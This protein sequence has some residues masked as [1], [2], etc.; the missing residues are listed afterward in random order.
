MI[1]KHYL[2][3]CI[4]SFIGFSTILIQ[5]I[6]YYKKGQ[7]KVNFIFL[8]ASCILFCVIDF[9][10]GLCALDII[11]SDR[12]FFDITTLYY[13]VS[14]GIAFL[15]AFF[16]FYFCKDSF[17][18]LIF[19]AVI[20]F[21]PLLM[22][23]V[24]LVQNYFTNNL[25]YISADGVYTRNKQIFI[26]LV[27][28]MHYIYY[29]VCFF[30]SIYS[31]YL[32]TKRSEH[33]SR[34]VILFPILPIISSLL[35]YRDLAQ[36]H[37]SIGYFIACLLIYSFENSYSHGQELQASV[38]T[39]FKSI[40]DE[41]TS[42]LAYESVP[43]ENISLLLEKL[44]KYYNADDAFISVFT[45]DKINLEHI[46]YWNASR[47]ARFL[48]E[49]INNLPRDVYSEWYHIIQKRGEIY[50]SDIAFPDVPKSLSS[51]CKKL[52][53][54]NFMTVPIVNNGSIVAIMTV[55]NFDNF[56]R[57]FTMLRTIA[58][59][60]F[61]E[62]LKRKA[63]DKTEEERK[64]IISALSQG[65]DCIYYIN[66]NEDQI[67]VYRHDEKVERFFDI[68]DN[69]TVPFK[70]SY[71]F[72]VENVV[73]PEEQ[74]ELLEFGSVEVLKSVLRGRK[75][76]TK[77]FKSHITEVPETFEAKW[78]KVEPEDQEAQHV[79]LG[80]TNIEA[81]IQQRLQEEKERQI[82]QN[83]L[84]L[85]IEVAE[86]VA[87][88]SQFDKLTGVYNKISGLDIMSKFLSA[89]DEDESYA[90]LFFDLDKF[91]DINDN[92]GHLEGDEIL[93]GVGKA[94]KH[95]CRNCD[96]AV[97]FGGD[98]FI[99]LVKQMST[100]TEVENFG[101]QIVEQIEKLARGKYYYTTCSMGGY[102]TK[103]RDLQ[104]SL[105]MAD[106]SLYDVKNSGRDGIKI[107]IDNTL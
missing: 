83:K 61:S 54:K 84:D 82:V 59:F 58:Y 19:I 91:K 92:H 100:A 80:Y 37:L 88:E 27:Y 62:V 14:G 18:H 6:K 76:V 24:L 71:K 55:Y 25:F 11:P 63:M 46:F 90:L 89:K 5:H 10:W 53:I 9:F 57:E 72:Y 78:V 67:T 1:D 75:S 65:Y 32:A 49:A 104:R 38:N 31:Y 42:L 56:K 106:K 93:K 107:A 15:F 98:E 43:E 45:D 36:P 7:Y 96:I 69:E 99:I 50:I 8:V 12:V 2:M 40:L 28:L 3:F 74:E 48:T 16:I 81:K 47:R 26:D 86:E 44:V 87:Y 102:I 21:V 20:S 101:K 73:V 105:D 34:A 17:K 33:L 85:A 97:R 79:V 39:K 68:H 95:I 77:K 29:I 4:L 30:I 23:T 70:A 13:L 51:F 64:S 22:I 35:Q 52:H 41:C 66:L 94:I 103:S 60:T